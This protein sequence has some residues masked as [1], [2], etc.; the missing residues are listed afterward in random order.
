MK[1]S[2]PFSFFLIPIIILFFS[3]QAIAQKQGESVELNGDV[4]EY[5]KNGQ[6]VIASGNVVVVRGD[7]TLMGDRIEF[8]R[9]TSIAYA[10]GN[11]RLVMPKGE[12]EGNEMT[13]N[14]AEMTGEFQGAKIIADPYYG[15][16]KTI[17]KINENHMVMKDGFITTCDYDKP[18]Y[19]MAS[20]KMDIYPGDKM[21][22]RNV[23]MF[24]GKV[25]MLFLPRFSQSLKNEKPRVTF[26]PGFDKKWGMFVLSSWRY[27]LNKN[28]KGVIHLDAREKKDIAWGV[29]VNYKTSNIG[30]G[31]IRT[32]YMNERNITSKRFFQPRPSPTIER[33][34]F[35]VQWRHKWKID[36]KTN[37]IMQYYKLS[38][39]TLLRDYFR[40]ENYKEP[41]PNTFF[42]LTR[43]LPKGALSFRTDI[44]ANRFESLVERLPELRYDLGNQELWGTGLYLKNVTTYSNLIKKT[45][46]PSEARTKT[47][48]LHTDSELSYPMKIGFIEFKPYIGSQQTYYSRAKN[49]DQYNSIRGIFKTGASLSTKFYKV[50]DVKTN[51]LGVNINRLRHIITPSI[52]YNYQGNPTIPSSQLDSFDGVD[53]LSNVHSINFSLENKLQ[54][55]RNRKVVELLRF[56]LSSPFNLKESSS[57][58]GFG[59]IR[60]DIDFKPL[61]W[62]TFYLDSVY[63]TYNDRLS[64]VNFDMYINGGNKWHANIGKRW[65]RNA[66]DQL[67]TEFFYKLNPKWTT[68][69]YMRFDVRNGILK[70]Q[71]FTV[72]RDMH[73]W[74]VEVNFNERRK[75]GNEIWIIFRLKA[76]PDMVLDVFGSSFNKR[77]AGSQSSEGE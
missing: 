39:S 45:A 23:R 52:S 3:T 55:K 59:A 4:M 32:Y 72:I 14:F 10:N 12:I 18:H 44:R 33:E 7:T 58:G 40:R 11:V 54:T 26:T 21:V 65:N 20:R 6:T 2:K 76:F 30:E 1:F 74:K 22:A 35:R 27:N 56:V 60:A 13:F 49:K 53:S 46:A 70:E 24:L 66:D 5:S 43:T 9:K 36:K 31:S 47:M 67:T 68:K 73:A 75:R 48:R 37:A 62:V 63:D 29:D 8:S 15:T 64:T 34:R 25:P 16:G 69:T 61:N 57:K 17:S 51:A 42:L 28:L 50:F 77:K 71:R 19:G 41:T 38:D